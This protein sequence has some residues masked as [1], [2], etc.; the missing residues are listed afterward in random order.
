MKCDDCKL[1]TTKL[2]AS[3]DRYANGMPIY[4]YRCA[5]CEKEIWENALNVIKSSFIKVKS[6]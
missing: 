2:F 6:Q 1:T 5:T 4:R 3:I